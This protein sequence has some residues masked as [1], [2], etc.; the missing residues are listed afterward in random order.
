MDRPQ[1]AAWH[2]R[3][4]AGY[5]ELAADLG[6]EPRE[7][8][9]FVSPGLYRRRYPAVDPHL[10]EGSEEYRPRARW[11]SHYNHGLQTPLNPYHSCSLQP[12]LGRATWHQTPGAQPW[13]GSWTES[14]GY[15]HQAAHSRPRTLYH[16]RPR[17]A[18]F[19]Y[20]NVFVSEVDAQHRRSHV[21]GSGRHVQIDPGGSTQAEGWPFYADRVHRGQGDGEYCDYSVRGAKERYMPHGYSL[22]A[23]HRP[24]RRWPMYHNSGRPDRQ[25]SPA[26]TYMGRK[27]SEGVLDSTYDARA[28]DTG[29]DQRDRDHGIPVD[30]YT[31]PDPHHV[32]RAE[33]TINPGRKRPYRKPSSHP[34]I[35]RGAPMQNIPPDLHNVTAIR[36][37]NYPMRTP[38][39]Q[40]PNVRFE[41][42]DQKHSRIHLGSTKNTGARPSP[43]YSASTQYHAANRFETFHRGDSYEQPR[44]VSES[45][46]DNDLGR[47]CF[48]S[49]D[50]GEREEAAY[51]SLPHRARSTSKQVHHD[52]HRCALAAAALRLERSKLRREWKKLHREQETLLQSQ[53]RLR[54][55]WRHLMERQPRRPY[56]I[57]DS[58]SMDSCNEFESS[59]E[60]DDAEPP[61]RRC[62]QTRAEDLGAGCHGGSTTFEQTSQDPRV[63]LDLY[64]RHWNA[65]ASGTG[66]NIPWP[67]SDLQAATLSKSHP[68]TPR[69]LLNSAN[70]QDLLKWN[71]FGFFTSAFGVR[72]TLKRAANGIVMDIGASSLEV[73]Q[74]IR[75]QTMEDLKRWHQDKLGCRG[76][77]LA[78]DE[79][80][81]AVFAAVH[82]LFGVCRER[83]TGS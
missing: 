22:Q 44:R 12:E 15:S 47:G 4:Q 3:R 26:H 5:C 25:Y 23:D 8:Y 59:A 73:V 10:A 69:A 49:Q 45:S 54:H 29:Q 46:D 56:H 58:E 39:S 67:T 65:L 55:G 82:E 74:A 78:S 60:S 72:P 33:T 19:R 7:T 57:D 75:N 51:P 36:L 16:P 62:Q 2:H 27:F 20:S 6:D 81:K 79:R 35:N 68:H 41:Q 21:H 11:Y 9:A 66:T 17:S 77:G 53:R 50:T 14:P 83:I 61:P 71:A 34:C 1:H 64:N 43:C 76:V 32:L 52:L 24:G 42:V 48:N 80:A 63:L 38:P 18:R 13:L 31:A 40:Q 37:D 28:S 30:N 70:P